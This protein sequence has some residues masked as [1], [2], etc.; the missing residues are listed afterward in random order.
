VDAPLI[1]ASLL[2]AWLVV[3][4]AGA[5]ILVLAAHVLALQQTPMP[6][7]RRRIRTANGLLMM[8]I[9]SLLAYALGVAPT[10]GNPTTNPDAA[11]TFLFVW[12]AIMSLLAVVIGLAALDVAHTA[13]LALGARSRL[14]KELRSELRR[15]LD[16][17][18]NR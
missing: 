6:P 5:A 7:R 12:S 1:V 8:L 4:I 3:P 16:E 10:V 17:H 11:R 15:E 9:S 13:K 18:T 14:R 2:P